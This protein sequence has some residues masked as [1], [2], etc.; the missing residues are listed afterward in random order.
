M[1]HAATAKLLAGTAYH[2]IEPGPPTMARCNG[3]TPLTATLAS[4]GFTGRVALNL[5]ESAA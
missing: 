5:G 3:G 2:L 4:L 1:L